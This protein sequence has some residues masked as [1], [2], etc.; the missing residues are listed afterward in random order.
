MR[1]RPHLNILLQAIEAEARCAQ[2]HANAEVFWA[3]IEHIHRLVTVIENRVKQW[4]DEKRWT[5][6]E[7]LMEKAA[8]NG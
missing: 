4:E 1:R 3:H 6:L 2:R 8:G 5:E 7:R